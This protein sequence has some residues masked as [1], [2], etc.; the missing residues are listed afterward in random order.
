MHKVSAAL[1]PTSAPAPRAWFGGRSAPRLTH[2][3]TALWY[4]GLD[5]PRFTPPGPVIGGTWAALYPLLAWAGYRVL[6]A[7][8]SVAR[9]R[10][11]AAWGAN[12]AGLAAH[13][14]VFFGRK[15]LAPATAVLTVEVGAAMALVATASRLDRLV[16][17]GQVPLALWTAFADVCTVGMLIFAIG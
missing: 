15:Q 14:Y 5:K 17:W 12:L 3:R 13:P 8:P 10:A 1:L 9:D 6:T 4:A 11:V 2:P 7:P 16:A